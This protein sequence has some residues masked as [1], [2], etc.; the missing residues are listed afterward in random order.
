MPRAYISL[1]T[2]LASALL[3]LGQIPRADAKLMS[4]GQ[5]ISLYNF[6]HIE[7]FSLTQNDTYWNLQP[8][9]IVPHREKSRQ[10]TSIAAKVKRLEPAAEEFRRKVLAKT[11]GA[12]RERLSRIRSRGFGPK[13]PRREKLPLPER[14]T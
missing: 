5:L 13:K 14:R 11:C 6:D 4:E 9:M 12:T 2:K 7:L 1:R 3:A 10:D 8:M